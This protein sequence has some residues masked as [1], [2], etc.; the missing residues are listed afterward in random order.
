MSAED[1]NRDIERAVSRWRRRHQ[2]R[3]EPTDAKG[4][5][6]EIDQAVADWRKRVIPA[7]S[8]VT[9][10]A[11]A[12]SESLASAL[13]PRR[14][15]RFPRWTIHRAAWLYLA[16]V[17]G[18]WGILQASAESSA[19]TSWFWQ[20]PRWLILAPW[21][22]LLVPALLI[23][24]RA[25]IP[26]TL[27]L[28]TIWGPLLGGGLPWRAW[29]TFPGEAPRLRLRVLTCDKGSGELSAAALQEL[30]VES[31]SDLIALQNAPVN[32]ETLQEQF[33]KWSIAVEGDLVV[34]S[35]YPIREPKRIEAN[36]PQ[37]SKSKNAALDCW[38]E[39]PI[40]P[41]RILNVYM[42]RPAP[43]RIE[44]SER[45]ASTI[46]PSVP[47][48]LILGGFGMTEDAPTFRRDWGRFTSAFADAGSGLGYTAA[49]SW[50]GLR[51]DHILG[52]RGWRF[53]S[54]ELGP[55]LGADHQPTLA[56]AY[57]FAR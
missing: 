31:Q 47:P 11:P 54:C 6:R 29:L 35:R 20:G 45:I 15:S 48:A 33:P 37:D 17:L 9:P 42:R 1:F 49:T 56:E 8:A 55:D 44:A 38:I 4:L 5:E 57:W 3:T 53:A 46:N 26:L 23:R 19:L 27:A 16:L 12:A 32:L 21:L 13:V 34:I 41:I 18:W 22:G 7:A 28:A 2:P 14:K 10:P 43:A 51:L 39:T 25:L 24:K 36:A 30:I 40:G 50:T 52:N